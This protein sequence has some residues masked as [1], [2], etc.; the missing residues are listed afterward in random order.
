MC[1][2]HT[3]Y[4]FQAYS[5]L[6]CSSCNSFDHGANSYRYDIYA[7][8]YVN[9][10]AVIETMKEQH[11]CFV[12]KMREYGLLQKTNPSP[13]SPRLEVSLYDNYESSLPLEDVIDLS[14]VAPPLSSIPKDTTEGVLH[15][16]SSPFPL[17]QCMGLELGESLRGD[18]S[19]VEND[20][21]DWS[22]DNVLKEPS[23]KELYCDDVRVGATPSF[24]HIDPSCT[25]LLDLIPISSPSLPTTTSQL[26]TF[27]ESLGDLRGY[28]PSLDPYY[29]YLADMPRKIM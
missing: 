28:T 27:S 7:D 25:E 2:S 26:P 5:L 8:C 11:E 13:S 9:L 19:F 12:S 24:E 4:D 23:F 29:V 6:M 3:S 20:L 17:A 22:R 10:T 18:A 15:L 1:P 14:F 16:L 21:L